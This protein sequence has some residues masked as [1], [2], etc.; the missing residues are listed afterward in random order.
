[1]RNPDFSVHNTYYVYRIDRFLWAGKESGQKE[2]RDLLLRS[3][4]ICIAPHTGEITRCTL[5]QIPP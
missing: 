5:K 2:T 3:L 4:I 1:M